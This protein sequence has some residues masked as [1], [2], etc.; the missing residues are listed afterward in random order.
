MS[1]DSERSL[2]CKGLKQPMACSALSLTADSGPTAADVDCLLEPRH[3]RAR[4]REQEACCS[5]VCRIEHVLMEFSPGVYDKAHRWSE[6][7]DWPRMLT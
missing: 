7:P 5:C 6:Y 3:S 2:L 4:S 1:H